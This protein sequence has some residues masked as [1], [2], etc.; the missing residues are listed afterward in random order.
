[1]LTYFN[2]HFLLFFLKTKQNKKKPVR[3]AENIKR[4]EQKVILTYFQFEN[5]C[6][7]TSRLTDQLF[8]YASQSQDHVPCAF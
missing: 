6:F 3:T 2:I 5:E 1:M 7:A 4:F 8:L